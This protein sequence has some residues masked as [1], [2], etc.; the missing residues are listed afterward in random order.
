MSAREGEG[1]NPKKYSAV[2]IVSRTMETFSISRFF[3]P[4]AKCIFW[5]KTRKHM[6]KV[7]LASRKNLVMN[8]G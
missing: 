4:S 8:I 2:D 1:Q 5:G 6:N 7:R 3:S